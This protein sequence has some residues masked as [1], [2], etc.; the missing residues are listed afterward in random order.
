MSFDE[1]QS[2]PVRRARRPSSARS[3]SVNVSP[4]VQRATPTRFTWSSLWTSPSLSSVHRAEDPRA[5]DHPV[6]DIA[7]IDSPRGPSIT[8]APHLDIRA[9]SVQ[10]D[11]DSCSQHDNL[12]DSVLDEGVSMSDGSG[13][14]GKS[15][16]RGHHAAWPASVSRAGVIGNSG[17]ADAGIL[18]VLS[19]PCA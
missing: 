6:L 12:G 11:D 8:S 2:T 9:S 4:P 10:V 3:S 5:V 18:N 19:L 16:S 13:K 1:A 7:Q 14:V 15:S 17:F